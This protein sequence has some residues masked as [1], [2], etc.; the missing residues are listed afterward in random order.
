M[1]LLIALP[2]S[3]GKAAGGDGPAVALDDL[4]WAA[5][6]GRTRERVAKT[7]VRLCAVKTEKA[8]ARTREVLGLPPGPATTAATRS[9]RRS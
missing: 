5:E 4:S 6:L 9:P 2:P 3:E 8:Q 1:S 7:L